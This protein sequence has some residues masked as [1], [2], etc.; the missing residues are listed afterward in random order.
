MKNWILMGALICAAPA[1]AAVEWTRGSIVKVEPDKARVTLKHR[2]IK[3]I[4]M[5]AMTMPFKLADKA[6]TKGLTRWRS[7]NDVADW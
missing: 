2:R 7:S 6:L 1:W 3:S 4:G 5:E